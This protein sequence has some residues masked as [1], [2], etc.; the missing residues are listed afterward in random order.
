MR[1]ARSDSRSDSNERSGSNDLFGHHV[2]VAQ[3]AVG[4]NWGV[5]MHAVGVGLGQQDETVD[6]EFLIL[7]DRGPVQ[8][9]GRGDREF[10]P[11]EF[12]R[13]FMLLAYLAQGVDVAAGLRQS[14]LK[15]YQPSA[16]LTARRKAAGPSPPT[17]TGGPGRCT[18]RGWA[19]IPAN[20]TNRP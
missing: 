8:R 3:N 14:R 5:P 7:I 9:P 4:W 16:M 11:A 18:G 6:A 10:Q 15:P 1:F 19:S 2:D 20:E 17:T 12:T 13:P